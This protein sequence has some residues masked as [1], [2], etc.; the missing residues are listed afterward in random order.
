LKVT[1]KTAWISGIL[2]KLDGP[3]RCAK[4]CVEVKSTPHASTQQAE[5]AGLTHM[6]RASEFGS[7]LVNFPSNWQRM[8]KVR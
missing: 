1:S 6:A 5:L 8:K 7:V 2:I 4:K 3:T